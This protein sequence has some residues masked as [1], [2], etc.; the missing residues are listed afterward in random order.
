MADIRE[1]VALQLVELANLAE[2]PLKLLILPRQFC[3]GRFFFGNVAAF[4][5]QKHNS[6]QLIADRHH[7]EVDNDRLF[8]RRPSIDLDVAADNLAA[9]SRSMDGLRAKRRSLSTSRW[10]RSAISWAE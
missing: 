5:Q 10:C 7:R 3:F 6:A 9:T 8:A 2:K 1:Q 4:G